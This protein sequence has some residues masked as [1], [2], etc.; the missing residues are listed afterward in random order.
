MDKK[1]RKR[2]QQLEGNIEFF[3]G[4]FDVPKPQILV[5]DE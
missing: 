4:S 1:L 3:G 2:R 5:K